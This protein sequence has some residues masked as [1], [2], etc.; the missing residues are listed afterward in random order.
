M[1]AWLQRLHRCDLMNIRIHHVE[2]SK[3]QRELLASLKV[4]ELA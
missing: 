4:P 1:L 2:V 3:T